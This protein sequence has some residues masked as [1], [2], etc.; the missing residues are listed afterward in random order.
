MTIPLRKISSLPSKPLSGRL[1]ALDLGA[2]RVG[3]AV[4]DE[5]QMTVRP[6]AYLPRSNWKKL[7]IDLQA[8]IDKWSVQAIII[9]LP[10]RLDGTSGDA[11]KQ[12][13]EV[14]RRLELSLPI[15]IYLQDERMT[16]LAAG[17]N[18]KSTGVTDYKQQRE[19]I[20]S[21]AAALILTDFLADLERA[22]IL[23]YFPPDEN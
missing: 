23:P 10:L 17:E 12:T 5:L 15:P 4:S 16:S 20:D 2:K 19:M 14:A 9:G 22:S 6:L 3:V 8:L 1:L 21:E 18:L 13:I 7:L 11:A